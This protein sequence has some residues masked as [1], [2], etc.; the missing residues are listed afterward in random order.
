[1]VTEIVKI[2]DR[3]HL[4]LPKLVAFDE[5]IDSMQPDVSLLNLNGMFME[6]PL[7]N[8]KEVSDLE[9]KLSSDSDF[10]QKM[11]LDVSRFLFWE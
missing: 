8:I 2:Q 3:Q 10:Y 11:V 9:E 6:A 4:I 7:Q 5:K 1:M